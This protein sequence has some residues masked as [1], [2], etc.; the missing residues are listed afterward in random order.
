MGV[1]KYYSRKREKKKKEDSM[2]SQTTKGTAREDQ[3][4]PHGKI[5]RNIMRKRACLQK[6]HFC[7]REN[8]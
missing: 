1:S 3:H 8:G 5:H 7:L 6:A 4:I 2:Y